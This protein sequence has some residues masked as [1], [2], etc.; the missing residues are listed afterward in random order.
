MSAVL[1]LNRHMEECFVDEQSCAS[2]AI[3]TSLENVTEDK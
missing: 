1:K 3:Y 2:L